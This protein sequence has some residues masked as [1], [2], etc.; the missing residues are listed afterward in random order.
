LL[1]A[2][3]ELQGY[4]ETR[5]STLGEQAA[6]V[7][8]DG[9][10]ETL[11]NW[12]LNEADIPPDTSI[13]VLDE[14]SVDL[15]GRELPEQYLDFVKQSVIGKPVDPQSNYQPVRLAPQ[16]IAPNGDRYAFLILPKGISVWGSPATMLSLVLVALLVIASVAWLIA[17][18]LSNPISEL[19]L[20][21]S[22]LAIGHTYARIPETISKRKDELGSLAAN[23]NAMAEQLTELI[24]GREQLMREM[25]HELRSPLARLHAAIAL[26][27]EKGNLAIEEHDRVEHEIERMNHVIGELLRYS[28]IDTS[29]TP[30]QK[31]VRIDKLLKEL[32]VDEEIEAG[33]HNCKLKLEAETSL[34]VIGDPELL[35]S[36][37]ENI[38]RNAIR[39]APPDS[40]IDI[41]AGMKHA[42]EK[43]AGQIV[44]NISDH[45]PG[46]AADQLEQI[47]EPYYR[48]AR[49]A[50][51]KDSTGLGLAIV[52]RI[53]AQHAGEVSATQREGGGLTVCVALPSADL[54]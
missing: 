32:V 40:V 1:I 49:G 17:R 20:A 21:V 33:T 10:P 11:R 19:Q 2:A 47:F 31:L 23:F 14:N 18:A 39:Y 28:L 46:V 12:L 26:A 48:V 35:H 44:V 29:I 36:C 45:G 7:L 41:S 13:Y 53:T 4:I 3:S 5:E 22:E 25:S 30:K 27:A 8:A 9:G 24:E 16:L 15:L 6:E 51:H 50:H 52:K 42:A 37:F 54:S 43:A 38:L 34:A